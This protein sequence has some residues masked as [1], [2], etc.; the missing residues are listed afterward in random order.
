MIISYFE[1]VQI[2]CFLLADWRMGIGTASCRS[3]L[4]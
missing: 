4:H 3:S 1:N 2:V